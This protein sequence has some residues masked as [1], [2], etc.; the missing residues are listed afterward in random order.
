MLKRS[1]AVFLALVITISLIGYGKS[2]RQ[3]IKLTLSTEDSEAQYLP[4]QES[5]CPTL[6]RQRAP[7]R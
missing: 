5:I 7:I 3:P 2:G 1:I 6:R 4:P